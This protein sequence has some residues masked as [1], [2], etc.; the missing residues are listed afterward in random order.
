MKQELGV[1]LAS[2]ALLFA[3][4]KKPEW[5]STTEKHPWHEESNL[6]FEETSNMADVE[7]LPDSVL[8]TIDGFGAC[9]NELGWTSL[10]ELNENDRNAVFKE[11]FSPGV[12]A[13]FNICRMPVGANDFSRD[14]YSYDEQ[15]GDFEMKNFTIAHDLETLVPFIKEAQKQYPGLQ[16]WASPWS[17]PSWMKWNKHY[18]CHAIY[19]GMDAKFDNHLAPDKQGLEGTNMFIQDSTYFKAYALYFSKFIESYKNQGITISTIM[20]QNEFNSCQI[21]PSC[22]WTSAGLSLEN[23]WVRHWKIKMSKLC[24]ALWSARLKHSQTRS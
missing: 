19:K 6:K 15:E 24:L 10:K 16:I 18:A 23:T 17:P 21:F 12:G 14:W 13:N 5:V 3:C 8:Q 2:V 4:Q 20:P 1:I 22:T 9:F 7:I 11:L